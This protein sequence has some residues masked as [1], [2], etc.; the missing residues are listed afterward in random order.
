MGKACEGRL[1]C[2][3]TELANRGRK[4]YDNYRWDRSPAVFLVLE[5][6]ERR[7]FS[8][9]EGNCSRHSEFSL[10]NP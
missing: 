10:E 2:K 3:I 8:F 4:V 6:A 1:L 7:D 9:A 5:T